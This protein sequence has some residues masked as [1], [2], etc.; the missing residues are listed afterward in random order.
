MEKRR[1][2]ER[3]GRGERTRDWEDRWMMSSL[4]KKKT[5]PKLTGTARRT[6][7]RR[8]GRRRGNRSRRPFLAKLWAKREGRENARAEE[9]EQSSFLPKK[10]SS[11]RP[12]PLS[13]SLHLPLQ[14]FKRLTPRAGRSGLQL[15]H[16]YEGMF[17]KL[18]RA[19]HQQLCSIFVTLYPLSFRLD[20]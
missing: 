8:R 15:F 1:R 11:F 17:T 9:K 16:F 10:C 7:P 14:P 12:P 18:A 4:L 2:K 19:Q 6:C 20:P 3:K 13:S 5:K